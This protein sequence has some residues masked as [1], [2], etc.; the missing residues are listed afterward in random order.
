MDFVNNDI[1]EIAEETY[2]ENWSGINRFNVMGIHIYSHL[3]TKKRPIYI[4]P[5]NDGIESIIFEFG[6]HWTSPTGSSG[7]I[8]KLYF[9]ILK[10]D[11]MLKIRDRKIKKIFN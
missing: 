8:E 2:E 11:I 5:M 9:T 3:K 1:I 4:K 6:F 10:S 7:G